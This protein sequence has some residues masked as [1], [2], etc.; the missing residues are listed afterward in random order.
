MSRIAYV[1]GQYKPLSAPLIA[2]ED[3]GF[4]F[5]DGIYEVWNI[6]AGRR[7]DDA[8]HFARLWRSLK[9]L[10]IPRPMEEGALKAALAET[11]RRNR[12]RDGLLY[13]QVTRVAAPRD[14]RFPGVGVAPTVVI[15]A[16][17]VDRRAV[18]KRMEEGVRVITAP[19]IRWGRCDIKSVALLPN[20]LAKQAAA[21][22]G[23]F[24]A[25]LLDA[26]GNITEGASS[27]AW[28]VSHDGA[29]LTRPLGRDILAGVTRATLMGAAE[30]LQLRVEER[31]FTVAEAKAAREAFCTS[32]GA[33]LTPVIA[34][35]GAPVGDG[36]PGPLAQ[37]L[38]YA[39]LAAA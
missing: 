33:I 24:E 8:G 15:T 31:A 20:V 17:S 14:H 3:R 13:L 32:A 28:I 36:R 21:E 34:I 27:N 18:L 11:L 38:R 12:V 25:W 2:V 1:N 7:L 16:R 35:D 19:D 26:A 22:A 39:Y 4:Q 6:R 37:R 30:A 23:A 10:S 9:E 5:A 29:I